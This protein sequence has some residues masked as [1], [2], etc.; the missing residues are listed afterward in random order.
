MFLVQV[1]IQPMLRESDPRTIWITLGVVALFFI[2]LIIGNSRQGGGSGGGKKKSPSGRFSKRG[3]K[4]QS[5]KMGL[6]KTQAASLTHLVQKYKLPNPY[7]IFSRPKQL[8]NLLKRAISDV[9][10]QVASEKNIEAQKTTLYRI[11][12]TIERNMGLSSFSGGS[13]SIKNGQS[14][15]VSPEGGGRYKSKL[16]ANLKDALAISIP[17]GAGGSPVR[18]KKWSPIKIFFWKSNG[19]GFGFVSKVS[20]YSTIKGQPCMLLQHTKKVSQSRQRRFR[21]KNT[22]RP[23]YYHPVTIVST[24]QGKNQTKRAIVEGGRGALGTILDISAGG[25]AMKAN[26]PLGKGQ[27]LKIQFETDTQATVW[28][29]GKIVSTSKAQPFGSVMHI[30]FTKL[31]RKNLNNINAF[32]YDFN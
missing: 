21:R 31:S 7:L 5:M 23:A 20:G 4:K 32:V 27:L 1:E 3:F 10:M 24:G 14:L 8:D 2:V 17:V 28:A 16:V 12:Q 13:R 19:Q 22:Q 6:N 11:K 30:K 15:A 25:C 18:F 9:E 29:F 26:R